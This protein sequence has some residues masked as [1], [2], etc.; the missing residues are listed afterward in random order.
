VPLPSVDTTTCPCE[1]VL[2]GFGAVF[3]LLMIIISFQADGLL[4]NASELNLLS[5]G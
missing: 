2:K 3:T 1:E 4:G 5:L